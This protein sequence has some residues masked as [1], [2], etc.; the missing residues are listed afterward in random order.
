M[1]G[2][3]P[4]DKVELLEK[5]WFSSRRP[6]IANAKT[7]A[8][9]KQ[10][11]RKLEEA[12]PTLFKLYRHELRS[13]DGVRHF[14]RDSGRF[15]YGSVGRVNTF[16]LFAEIAFGT[17]SDRGRTGI[18]LPTGLAVDDSYKEFFQHLVD[19]NR[20]IS[21]F[22]FENRKQLFPNVQGNVT[23][24]CFTI[25]ENIDGEIAMAAQLDDPSQLADPERRYSLSKHDIKRINP[26]TRT[27]PIFRRA[28]DA[29]LVRHFYAC[30]PVICTE[31]NPPANPYDLRW[32][33]GLFNLTSDSGA[34]RTLE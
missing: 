22:D 25:G 16:G 3:P 10:A 34:F 12:D 15:P 14:A 33:Q 20:L 30:H 9:R 4:W 1:I 18:L 6:E 2:N 32:R 7:A 26:N 8:K 21:L 17:I 11:I 23:F 27:C 5:E 29:Q 31:S 24:A 13:T 28:R 19:G